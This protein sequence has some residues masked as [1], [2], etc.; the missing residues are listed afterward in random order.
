M[1]TEF[2]DGEGAR[3]EDCLAPFT[4][5]ERVW[6]GTVPTIRTTGTLRI[7]SACGSVKLTASG[8]KA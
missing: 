6:G 8:G 2:L 7:D 5:T 1:K 4:V 3:L